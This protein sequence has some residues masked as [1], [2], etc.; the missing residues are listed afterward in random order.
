LKT[1][2]RQRR[3]SSTQG[4]GYVL[5]ELRRYR[6]F[7]EALIYNKPIEVFRDSLPRSFNKKNLHLL[8]WAAM[9]WTGWVNLNLDKPEAVSDIPKVEAMLEFINSLDGK[10]KNGS[11]HAA[12]GTIY[13]NRSKEEG[14]SPEKAR[15]E[16]EKA[17]AC[18]EN[19]I[20]AYQ[21]MFARYYATRVQDRELFRKTLATGIETPA[22]PYEDRAFLNEVARSKAK[23]FMNDMDK[24]FK[25]AGA[26]GS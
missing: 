8:Y 16:F 20:L 18:S 3:E 22:N 17:F 23:R 14:G 7:D 25:E 12:L 21:V 9:N 24:Y 4:R 5:K 2:T 6:I 1:S 26:K 11:V 10:Y 15:E 13:A 19:G